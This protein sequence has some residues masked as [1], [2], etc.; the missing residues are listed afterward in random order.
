MQG[1]GL[2]EVIFLAARM[3]ECVINGD[4]IVSGLRL[5]SVHLLVFRLVQNHTD[6]SAVLILTVA[7]V[8]NDA[9]NARVL[10]LL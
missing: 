5:F 10:H 9:L 3:V 4:M 1:R 6:R 8:F 7:L 2:F